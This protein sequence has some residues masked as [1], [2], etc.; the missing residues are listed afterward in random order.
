MKKICFLFIGVLA[1]AGCD[2]P[3]NVYVCDKYTVEIT[4][5]ED[6]DTLTADING[7]VVEMNIAPSGD[8]ARYVAN[9]NDTEITLWNRGRD[10]T[11]FVGDEEPI[12]CK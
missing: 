3:D 12:E 6:G 8:G 1:F 11:L 4:P 2:K 9:L 5:T 10:W 7:D